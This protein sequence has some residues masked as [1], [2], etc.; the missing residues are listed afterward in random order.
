MSGGAHP[1]EPRLLVA[2]I[3]AMTR[4][5][6]RGPEDER[7]SDHPMIQVQ[8]LEIDTGARIVRRGGQELTLSTLEYDLLYLFA[9]NA[10]KVLSRDEILQ[11]V[12]GLEY[13][14]VSRFVDISISRLRHKIG[15]DPSNPSRIKTIRNRGYLLVAKTAY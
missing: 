9:R 5:M 13:D 3:N 1:I 14:G 4:R 15:D 10:G 12:R 6:H 8:D 7:A 11:A 2:R